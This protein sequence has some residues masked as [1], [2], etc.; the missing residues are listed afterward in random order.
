MRACE[1]CLRRS[2]LLAALA[3]QI[4]H[5]GRGRGRVPALLALPDEELIAALCDDGP[6]RARRLL[7]GFDACDARRRADAAN[8]TAVCHH[9]DAFPPRLLEARDAPWLLY[10]RGEPGRLA[11]LAREPAVALVGSR[12]ASP[13][14]L[15]VAFSLGRELAACGVPVVSGMAFGVDAAAHEGALE[16][17]GPTVAVLGGGADA[18]SPRG[19]RALYNRIASVGLVVSEFPPGFNALSWCFPARNRIMAGL[20]AMTV[21]VE[22]GDRSG[23]LITARFATELGREVGAVPGQ[24]TSA[25]ARGPNGLLAD[26][27]CVVRSAVDVLDAL[28]GAGEGAR[29]LARKTRQ[30]LAPDLRALLTEVER[31]MDT[32]DLLTPT[33][34][35]AAEVLA[36]LTELELIGL[37]RRVGG[38]YVR[39]A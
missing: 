39:C 1:R 4:E 34:A 6:D 25:L 31:G 14:A 30:R 24:V 11:S 33:G 13:Y 32:V 36:T 35:D 23:S 8:L 27:A 10:L 22:G 17:D 5:L 15:E 28:Y 21:V 3:P 20:S 19:K 26:G 18:P 2:A 29:K 7:R 16:S 37:V 12:R 9:D 38:R